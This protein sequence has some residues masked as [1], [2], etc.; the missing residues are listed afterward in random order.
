VPF[1]C[2]PAPCPRHPK[3]LNLQHFNDFVIDLWGDY[4]WR[5][6]LSSRWY[7]TYHWDVFEI[8][9]NTVMNRLI[10]H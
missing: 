7:T 5:Q 8:A 3:S 2:I 6:G 1:A 4:E 9:V 10:G